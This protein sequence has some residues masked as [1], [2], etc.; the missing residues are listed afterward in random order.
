MT[1]KFNYKMK[2]I[3]LILIFL[4]ISISVNAQKLKKVNFDNNFKKEHQGK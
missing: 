3:S 1:I 2:N 4:I